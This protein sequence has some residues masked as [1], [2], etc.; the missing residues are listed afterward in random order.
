MYGLVLSQ[1]PRYKATKH[2]LTCIYCETSAFFQHTGAGALNVQV[3]IVH[4]RNEERRIV[5][6]LE[7]SGAFVEDVNAFGEGRVFVKD[8]PIA[9][10]V[11]WLQE[12][13][14]AIVT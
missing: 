9:R 14:V 7:G 13:T 5:D 4:A 12:Q 2:G 6:G 1:T 11:D 3:S 8:V 10:I